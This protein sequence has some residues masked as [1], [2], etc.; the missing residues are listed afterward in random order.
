ML[1]PSEIVTMVTSEP[2]TLLM[3]LWW[4][5]WKQLAVLQ[6]IWKHRT[7]DLIWCLI[8]NNDD[9]SVCWWLMYWL[10][11]TFYCYFGVHSSYFDFFPYNSTCVYT[12]NTLLYLIFTVSLNCTIFSCAW[13]NHMLFYMVTNCTGL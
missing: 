3:Y 6:V 13:F 10:Y 2:N 9:K 1:W 12:G 4:C 5:W 8:L 7:C 11:Y